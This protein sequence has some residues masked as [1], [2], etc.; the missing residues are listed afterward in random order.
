MVQYENQEQPVFSPWKSLKVKPKDIPKEKPIPIYKESKPRKKAMRMLLSAVLENNFG[1]N[2]D[3]NVEE[4]LLAECHVAPQSNV[5]EPSSIARSECDSNSIE[6][7]AERIHIAAEDQKRQ[8][9]KF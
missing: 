8:V 2:I 7:R 1:D 6:K 5:S 3:R 9:M 4:E